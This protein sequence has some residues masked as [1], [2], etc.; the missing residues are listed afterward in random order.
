MPCLDVVEDFVDCFVTVGDVDVSG[1]SDATGDEFG[2]MLVEG[3]V[4]K[5]PGPGVGTDDDCHVP[6]M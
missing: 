2:H 4:D 6:V 5:V 1:D 3:F